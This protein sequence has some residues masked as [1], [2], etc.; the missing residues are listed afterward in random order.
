MPMH[1]P[2]EPAAPW[3]E[4]V[5]TQADWDAADPDLLPRCTPSWCSSASSRSTCSSWP[6]RG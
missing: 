2:L 6:A 3:V 1:R 4:L 5:V